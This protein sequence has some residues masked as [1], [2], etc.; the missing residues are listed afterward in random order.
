MPAI[1]LSL[2]LLV[3]AALA[4][5]GWWKK[6]TSPGTD[7]T[8]RESH[9]VTDKGETEYHYFLQAKGFPAGRKYIG[10]MRDLM[11]PERL[12]GTGI[13]AVDDQ[14][15]LISGD[16]TEFELVIKDFL[17]GE[18]LQL[19]ILEEDTRI[20]NFVQ[21]TPIPLEGQDGPCHLYAILLDRLSYGYELHAAGFTPG[22]KI[23]FQG[24]SAGEVRDWKVKA[25]KD[26]SWFGMVFPAVK[27]KAS[28]VLRWQVEGDSCSP[29]VQIPWRNPDADKP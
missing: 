1:L 18:T 7:L 14:G 16:G 26:G 3:Q 25:N 19:S 4:Q 28:G 15:K 17:P 23:H 2:L 8:I 21:I 29:S 27:G 5:V 20:T 13:R 10:A 9:I 24:D 11:S 12:M 6:Y 22:K